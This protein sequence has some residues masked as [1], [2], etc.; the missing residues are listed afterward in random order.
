M[1]IRRP[2]FGLQLVVFDLLNPAKNIDT[3][4]FAT[5]PH[6]LLRTSDQYTTENQYHLRPVVMET[7]KCLQCLCRDIC[8]C[9]LKKKHNWTCRVL[10][11]DAPF[12]WS[13]KER[14]LKKKK[15][16]KKYSAFSQQVK[17]IS[18][19]V[20]SF[21]MVEGQFVRLRAQ[22]QANLI[23]HPSGVLPHCRRFGAVGS[24]RPSI[25]VFGSGRP[26]FHLLCCKKKSP[27]QVRCVTQSLLCHPIQM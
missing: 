2:S 23:F 11:T 9:W 15:K 1:L 14:K 10:T 12:S 13:E 22:R 4:S 16:K 26:L 27:S 17:N 21:I 6:I 19:E 8:C 18:L 7:L 24:F 25:L 5:L 20:P 3:Q